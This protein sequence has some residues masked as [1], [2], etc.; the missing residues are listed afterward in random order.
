MTTRKHRKHR[1]HR[2]KKTL[3]N[4]RK[5]SKQSKQSK[6]HKQRGGAGGFFDF[7]PSPI[8]DITRNTLTGIDNFIK[9]L[10]GTTTQTQSP[11]SHHQPYM[12]V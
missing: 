2:L 9:T 8:N 7:I 11:L 10:Y 3:L 1:K 5:Q 12:H 4:R 6:K